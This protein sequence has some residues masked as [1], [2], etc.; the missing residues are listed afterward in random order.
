MKKESETFLSKIGDFFNRVFR[1]QK[2]L[3]HSPKLPEETLPESIEEIQEIVKDLS[4][5]IEEFS[6]ENEELS[7]QLSA[8]VRAHNILL[9]FT[10]ISV[11]ASIVLILRLI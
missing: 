6:K 5:Q 7:Q 2:P 9:I 3:P 11:I 8:T 4:S 1:L 10:L